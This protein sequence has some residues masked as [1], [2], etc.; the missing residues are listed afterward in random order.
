MGQLST[1]IHVNFHWI[2]YAIWFLSWAMGLY[3]E[4]FKKIWKSDFFFFSSFFLLALQSTNCSIQRPRWRSCFRFFFFIY[5]DHQIRFL[6]CIFHSHVSLLYSL[7]SINGIAELNFEYVSEKSIQ[8]IYFLSL[9][10]FLFWFAFIF[11]QL[12]FPRSWLFHVHNRSAVW[13]RSV[14]C[15]HYY[16][17]IVYMR[18]K[19]TSS[20]LQLNEMRERE[21]K[22]KN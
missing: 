22:R 12:V 11:I 18:L 9:S 2:F 19:W 5:I 15:G 8:N 7:H 20:I 6:L 13:L 16:N 17:N 4:K 14:V 10:L 1:T 21:R 3:L